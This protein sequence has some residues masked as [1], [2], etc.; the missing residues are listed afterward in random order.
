VEGIAEVDD[1]PTASKKAIIVG[2]R[3]IAALAVLT[4]LEYL[5]SRELT[6]ATVAVFALAIVKGWLILDYFMHIR[7]LTGSHG[8][9]DSSDRE[10]PHSS[11]TPIEATEAEL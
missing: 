4:F 9:E 3:V 6:H 5:A 7:N 11:K 2:L 1:R 10:D 8:Y